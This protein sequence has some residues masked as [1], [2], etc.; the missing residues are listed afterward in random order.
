EY[1]NDLAKARVEWGEE[2]WAHL[3][4]TATQRKADALIR[5]AAR[6]ASLRTGPDGAELL[7]LFTVLVGFETVTD[8]ICETDDGTVIHPSQPLSSP[9]TPQPLPTPSETQTAKN[10]RPAARHRT[11]TRPATA[12]RRRRELGIRRARRYPSSAVR[13]RGQRRGDQPRRPS[14]GSAGL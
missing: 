4:R 8:R 5:M 3:P 1:E 12:R 13:T 2:A 14:C 11:A 6:S 7:P 10:R 9:W